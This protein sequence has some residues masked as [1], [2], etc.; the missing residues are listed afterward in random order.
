[1]PKAQMEIPG[2]ERPSIIEIEDAAEQYVKIR[3]KR[4]KLTEQEIV[5]RANL[6]QTMESHRKELVVN[7][8]GALIYRYDDEIVT[9]APGKVKVR[10]KRAGEEDEGE[11]ED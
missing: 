1:M 4:M 7:G 10:V 3:D 6:I 8:D 11:E 5:C 2:T 9:L